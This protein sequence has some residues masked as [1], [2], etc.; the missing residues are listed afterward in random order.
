[1]EADCCRQD[2]SPLPSVLDLFLSVVDSKSVYISSFRLSHHGC[3]GLSLGV[4]PFHFFFFKVI[5][6]C[7]SFILPKCPGHLSLLFFV[8]AGISYQNL[9]YQNTFF[10]R[11]Q[12][13]YPSYYVPIIPKGMDT[14]LLRTFRLE[15]ALMKCLVQKKKKHKR[16]IEEM[17]GISLQL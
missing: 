4:I 11:N 15:I 8:I 14:P 5:F 13:P 16:T 3:V 12:E 9:I 2:T 7:L 6:V 17:V 10:F 1:M